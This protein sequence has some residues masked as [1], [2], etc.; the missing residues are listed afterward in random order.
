[1]YGLMD[2]LI[3]RVTDLTSGLLFDHKPTGGEIAPQVVNTCL[4]RKDMNW[5]EGLDW[6]FVSV[7][8]YGGGF[9]IMAPQPHQVVIGCGIW[10]PGNTAE[11]TADIMELTAAVGRI[12]E[13]RTFKPFKLRSPIRYSVG[14]EQRGFEGSQ[15]HPYYVSAIYLEFV[16]F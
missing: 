11:G 14:S 4:P 5:Q 3:T 8:I 1:M 2:L 16:K 12:V 9:D 6:P 13:N 10:T 15:P 7:A